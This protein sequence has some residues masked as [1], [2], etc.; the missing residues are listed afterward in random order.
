MPE[1]TSGPRIRG[2]GPCIHIAISSDVVTP[3]IIPLRL[4]SSSRLISSFLMN[5]AVGTTAIVENRTASEERGRRSAKRGSLKKTATRLAVEAM[6]MVEK[7]P[8]MALVQKAVSSSAVVR[9][10][11]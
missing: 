7:T 8:M 5:T 11:D 4:M 6:R 10:F 2:R 9:D 1:P 3:T